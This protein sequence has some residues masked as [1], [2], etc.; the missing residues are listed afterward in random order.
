MYNENIIT[1]LLILPDLI[2]YFSRY[3]TSEKIAVINK[4]KVLLALFYIVS[5][6]D[7]MLGAFLILPIIIGAIIMELRKDKKN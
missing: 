5:P 3:L 4:T 6:V 1:T 7:I 2:V